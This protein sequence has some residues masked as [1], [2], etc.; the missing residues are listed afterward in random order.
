MQ[1]GQL[2]NKSFALSMFVS[3]ASD[4]VYQQ[5]INWYDA[6]SRTYTHIHT[7]TFIAWTDKQLSVV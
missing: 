1:L 3:A 4:I 6:I 5:Q 2:Q 7:P